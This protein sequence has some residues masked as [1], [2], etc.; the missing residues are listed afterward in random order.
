MQTVVEFEFIFLLGEHILS[1]I[2]DEN[3]VL[4]LVYED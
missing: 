4:V 2:Q 1:E 3:D